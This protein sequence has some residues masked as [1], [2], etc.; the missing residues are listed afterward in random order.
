M[1]PSG[2]RQQNAL[3]AAAFQLFWCNIYLLRHL[4][5]QN[6]PVSDFCEFLW[7]FSFQ[8]S[9]FKSTEPW[10]Q[11]ISPRIAHFCVNCSNMIIC[12][13]NCREGQLP[14]S[15]CL[16]NPLPHDTL[17]PAFPPQVLQERL[18]TTHSVCSDAIT[19]TLPGK[20]NDPMPVTLPSR[21]SLF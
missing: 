8:K 19:V 12:D 15:N 16:G 11:Q 6:S 20:L 4:E 2:A 9:I 1:S 10:P 17:L 5:M 13:L 7:E 21:S 14:S 3:K 18:R